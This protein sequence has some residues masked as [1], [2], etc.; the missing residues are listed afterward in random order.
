MIIVLGLVGSFYEFFKFPLQ[1]ISLELILIVLFLAVPQG[2]NGVK[3]ALELVPHDVSLHEFDLNLLLKV[4]DIVGLAFILHLF[5]L[6][7]L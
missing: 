4:C 2:I 6:E 7:L 1:D 3:Q 5:V